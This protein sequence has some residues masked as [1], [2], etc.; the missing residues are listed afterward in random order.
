MRDLMPTQILR[1][2]IRAI[3]AGMQILQTEIPLTAI[4][5]HYDVKEDCTCPGLS[6]EDCCRAILSPI[7]SRMVFRAENCSRSW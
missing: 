1:R 7:A 4:S 6:L 3:R 5:R 2:S